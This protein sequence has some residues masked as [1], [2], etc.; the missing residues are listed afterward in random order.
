MN[1]NTQIILTV[2]LPLTKND[3]NDSNINNNNV[4]DINN[5]NNNNE[6]IRRNSLTQRVAY[7][8]IWL[9]SL[10]LQSLLKEKRS[11]CQIFLFISSIQVTFTTE[12]KCCVKV[13]EVPA[14]KNGL[15]INSFG[16]NIPHSLSISF[17]KFQIFISL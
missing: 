4:D 8:E 13:N 15:K 5:D 2:I 11:Y 16:T 12:G 6:Q 17:L 10:P 1:D 9:P 7:I 3:N 14:P